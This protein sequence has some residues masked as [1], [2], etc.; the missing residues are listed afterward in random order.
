[1]NGTPKEHGLWLRYTLDPSSENR[2]RLCL[3]YIP[4]IERFAACLASKIP[5]NLVQ[6][7]DLIQIGAIAVLKCIDSFDPAKGLTFHTFC[8]NR[9]RGEILDELRRLDWMSRADRPLANRVKKSLNRTGNIR[10][11]AKELN[12]SEARCHELLRSREDF[13][14]DRQRACS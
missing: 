13:F 4:K 9:I 10:E 14:A 2:N 11:T 12:I 1:M 5:H 7:D 6:I 3:H 8:G